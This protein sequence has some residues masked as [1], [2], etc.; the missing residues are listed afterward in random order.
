FR[1]WERLSGMVHT[2]WLGMDP[3]LDQGLEP[4]PGQISPPFFMRFT[5][6][7]RL[8]RCAAALG[9]LFALGA[10]PGRLLAQPA[11]SN[12]PASNRPIPMPMPVPVGANGGTSTMPMPAPGSSLSTGS[13]PLNPPSGGSGVS[14]ATDSATGMVGPLKFGDLPVDAALDLLEQWTGRIVL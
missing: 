1:A 4:V 11:P 5:F 14:T 12:R 8:S 3:I 2:D 7:K 9:L 13:N 6:S 10:G